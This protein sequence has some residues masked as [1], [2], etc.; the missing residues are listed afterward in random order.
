MMSFDR[1]LHIL[2]RRPPAGQTL[3][4]PVSR[5]GSPRVQSALHMP[6]AVDPPG[7]HLPPLQPPADCRHRRPQAPFFEAPP[8][9]AH[10]RALVANILAWAAEPGQTHDEQEERE[11]VV[12]RLTPAYESGKRAVCAYAI[13]FYPSKYITHLPESFK[14]T[15]TV[16]IVD[17]ASLTHLPRG[18]EATDLF[19]QRCPALTHLHDLWLGG[20]LKLADCPALAHISEDF[21]VEGDLHLEKC[22]RLKELPVAILR[23]PA[24]ANGQ[25]HIIRLSRTGMS[26]A[27]VGAMQREA[28][29][30]VR[31]D[32]SE[33]GPD[34]VRC[35]RP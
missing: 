35:Q 16:S 30:G 14:A 12:N 25:P 28:G 3:S 19:I 1:I 34:R 26:P 6:P 31:F 21:Y 18:F 7:P 17:F 13:N 10:R 33:F 4:E 32:Y 22:P 24:R 8:P 5:I 20:T 15:D 11:G 2:N 23:W 27:T 29:P 9:V